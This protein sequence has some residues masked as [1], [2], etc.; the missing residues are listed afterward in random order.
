MKVKAAIKKVKTYFAKQNI[1]I[2]VRLV[3]HR[4]TFVHNGYVGSFL[5]NRGSNGQGGT[6]LP[7]APRE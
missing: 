3:G 6:Q 7:R 5:A 1:D 2:D 4:W